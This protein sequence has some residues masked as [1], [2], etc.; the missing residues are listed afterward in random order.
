MSKPWTKIVPILITLLLLNNWEF[1]PSTIR[2]VDGCENPA[3]NKK[4]ALSFDD[5]T[6]IPRWNGSLPHFQQYNV[7]A[8]FYIDR[9]NQLSEDD[10][11]TLHHFVEMGHEIGLHTLEHKSLTTHLQNG[12]NEQEWFEEQVIT[13]MQIM[14]QRGFEINSFAYPFG[15]RNTETD[16][17]V[18]TVIPVIRTTQWISMGI[19][20]YY[21]YC[22]DK[23]VFGAMSISDQK[24]NL[25]EVLSFIQ[26]KEAG[27]LL[28]YGHNINGSGDSISLQ[29]L[30]SI[31]QEAKNNDWEFITMKDLKRSEN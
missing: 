26:H 1:F 27:T 21:T 5:Q 13:S 30:V 4:I 29:N 17:L 28:L 18:H 23:G 31:F 19:E 25:D 24:N 10:Y 15:E 3:P 22:R 9:Q 6:H 2:L 11:A 20:P 16:D 7:N 8:T 14:E 12:G